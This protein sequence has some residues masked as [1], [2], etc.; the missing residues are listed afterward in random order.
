MSAWIVSKAHIDVLVQALA[1]HDL[2]PGS[3]DSNR[4][5]RV[6]PE[7]LTPETIESWLAT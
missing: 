1:D 3:S 4:T 2:L 7:P 6:A 5:A